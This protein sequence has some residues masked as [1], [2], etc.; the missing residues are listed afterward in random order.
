VLLLENRAFQATPAA[1]TLF[2]GA[3]GQ[4]TPASAGFFWAVFALIE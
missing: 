2:Q 3:A 1:V 4:A